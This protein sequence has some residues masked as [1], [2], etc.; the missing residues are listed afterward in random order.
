MMQWTTT[1]LDRMRSA[2]DQHQTVRHWIT[3]CDDAGPPQCEACGHVEHDE[4]CANDD[5]PEDLIGVLSSW[6]GEG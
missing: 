2:P 6:Y 3:Q 5:L 4:G 1:L